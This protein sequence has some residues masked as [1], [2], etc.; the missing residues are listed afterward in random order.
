LILQTPRDRLYRTV[1]RTPAR[2]DSESPKIETN[3]EIMEA[4]QR[5][6][7]FEATQAYMVQAAASSQAELSSS[8]KPSPSSYLG[9]QEPRAPA[10]PSTPTPSSYLGSQEPRAPTLPSTPAPSS[11]LWSQEPRAP[12]PSP[13]P[14]PPGP[15]P[16]VA[17]LFGTLATPSRN[18]EADLEPETPSASAALRQWKAL[19]KAVCDINPYAAPHGQVTKAWEEVQARLEAEG[20]CKGW[21]VARI[22]NAVKDLVEFKE[23]A[24]WTEWCDG[25]RVLVENRFRLDANGLTLLAAPLEKVEHLREQAQQ[26]RQEKTGAKRRAEEQAEQ[27]SHLIRDR[28]KRTMKNPHRQAKRV[29]KTTVNADSH[30]APD[31]QGGI[32][33]VAP[34]RSRES[35][36]LGQE[37]RSEA[38]R[39]LG[40]D[41]AITLLERY[42]RENRQ[43]FRQCFE[44]VKD[45]CEEI[46][47][48]NRQLKEEHREFK[49]EIKELKQM[50]SSL[51]SRER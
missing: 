47:E 43:E 40:V 42:C 9:S 18:K 1:I 24:T 45:Y 22:Q 49:Q 38:P 27:R 21:K 31:S 29:R 46:K 34:N 5:T 6:L 35:S 13:A 25:Q 17:A 50:I 12:T 48:Q 33:L 39:R 44:E 28:A 19:I 10:L 4:S 8:P 26:Q 51:L 30:V 2:R 14:A 41:R 16:A 11:Y 32:R 23:K 15:S 3:P 7:V 37:V 36:P 20:F